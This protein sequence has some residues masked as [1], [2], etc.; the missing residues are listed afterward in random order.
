MIVCKSSI[1]LQ[2]LKLRVVFWSVIT[3]STCAIRVC[4]RPRL[5][6]EKSP[7]RW[8]WRRHWSLSPNTAEPDNTRELATPSPEP[9]SLIV[10]QT[11]PASP[12]SYT[13][14]GPRTTWQNIPVDA[15]HGAGDAYQ[16][17]VS[18]GWL[19]LT[20][21]LFARRCLRMCSVGQYNKKKLPGLHSST[22]DWMN[23]E[24]FLGSPNLSNH[25]KAG[26]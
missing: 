5:L 2:Q 11:L 1:Q 25:T 12:M 3:A 22:I 26:V 10:A 14:M 9:Q 17:Q 19:H 18:I 4:C 16:A 7:L 15:C 21:I 20:L 6:N 24:P 8:Q 23:I 13:P